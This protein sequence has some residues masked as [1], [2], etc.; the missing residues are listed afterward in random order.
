MSPRDDR[1]HRSKR[2]YFYFSPRENHLSLATGKNLIL[3]LNKIIKKNIFPRDS[4][5]FIQENLERYP[6]I[7]IREKP[8]YLRYD[9]RLNHDAG[10]IYLCFAR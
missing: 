9:V 10:K 6:K 5:R 4:V 2:F 8:V 3:H 7:S 1:R